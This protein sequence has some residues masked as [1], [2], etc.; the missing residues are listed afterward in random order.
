M[1]E[2]AQVTVKLL[3]EQGNFDKEVVCLVLVPAG[4]VEERIHTHS[5]T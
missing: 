4:G 5:N 3:F 1:S 2:P